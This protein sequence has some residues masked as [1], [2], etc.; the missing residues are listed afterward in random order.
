MSYAK[1]AAL[2]C[3]N[4][5][6]WA[7]IEDQEQ[8]SGVQVQHPDSARDWI[9]ATLQIDS[10]QQLD[11]V[12][13]ARAKWL[14]LVVD[15][16]RWL[17]GYGASQKAKPW[18]SEEYRTLAKHA[19][20][21]RCQRFKGTGKVVAAHVMGELAHYFGK[22]LA[23]KPSDF[24]AA[25]LCHDC[26]GVMDSYANEEEPLLRTLEWA[27]MI[28]KTHDWLMRHGFVHIGRQA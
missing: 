8:G 11:Q 26:H 2:F 20:C 7:Y 4:P 6:F 24:A 17:T 28:L 13:E 27:V 16:N 14:A 22:G 5:K 19:P 23:E 9:Y 15:F 3:Q 25:Y 21:M 18:R 12:P 1:G 10:R